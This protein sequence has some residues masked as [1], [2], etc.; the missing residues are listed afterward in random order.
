MT[1]YTPGPR[2]ARTRSQQQ[3]IQEEMSESERKRSTYIEK[4]RKIQKS[5]EDEEIFLNWS[6][7]ELKQRL[8][9]LEEL[10]SNLNEI[11]MD[12]ICKQELSMEQTAE[13]DEID[14]LIMSLKAKATDKIEKIDGENK[15]ANTQSQASTSHSIRV[16]QT[17]A[18]GNLPNTWGTFNGDYAKWQSFRD[19]WLPVHE[20]KDIKSVTK[21]QA[22][23][24][25]C[26][27]EA[28]GAL[29]EWDLTDE[30][31]LKAF[32]RLKAIYEDEY[33]QTQAFMQK[34]LRLPRMRDNSSKTIRKMIDTVQQH[35]VGA[36]RCIKTDE[37]H[38]YA[39]FTVI[40]KMDSNT[41]SAWEKHRRALTEAQQ[42]AAETDE[43]GNQ[44]RLG[45]LI[46]SWKE[47]EQF[48]ESEV[49]IR[50][51][52]ESREGS[53][54][55][56]Q[57]T[58]H[59]QSNQPKQK[60]FK[61]N[62]FNKKPNNQAKNYPSYVICGACDGNHPVHKCDAFKA[63]NLL[64]RKN[65]A[66]E[67]QLCVKC[68]RKSHE[69]DCEIKRC[70]DACPQCPNKFH[71]SLLCPNS[72]KAF[73]ARS[74]SQ[75]G[76]KRP[77]EA[78]GKQKYQGKRPRTDASEN[79]QSS[80]Y[81]IG[82]WTLKAES[83]AIKQTNVKAIEKYDGES[84]YAILLATMNILIQTATNIFLNCR[85][86]SDGG[87]TVSVVEKQFVLKN[88]IRTKR[89]QKP[90]LGLTGPDVLKE[91]IKVYIH[92]WFNKEISI[93]AEL[94]VVNNLDGMYPYRQVEASKHDITHLKLADEQFDIP[95]PVD[96]LLGAEIYTQ[97]IDNVL[98][99]HKDGA[100]MQQTSFG[101]I[102]LGK[103]SVKQNNE[104]PILC[105]S[106]ANE[107]NDE[108]IELAKA[109]NKFWEIE[110]INEIQTDQNSEEQAV[111][112]IFMKTHFREKSGR[113]VVTIP[114]KSGHNLG[115]SR[116]IA[117]K[118]FLQLERKF[119]K[120]PATKAKYVEF[121]RNYQS[122]GYLQAAN[123]VYDTKNAYWLPHHAVTKKFRVV[124][125]ASQKTTTGES[126]NSIQMA[127]P[128]LQLDLALQLMRFRK[129]K[130]AVTTD[131]TK[132]FNKIGLNQKQWDFQRIFWRESP[133]HELK[134]YVITV[135]MFGLK[136]SPF[137]AVKTLMQ[138]ADDHASQFPEAA[139]AIKTCF[140][141]DDGIFGTN[142]IQEAKIL[143]KEV[144]YVLNRSNFTLKSWSSNSKEL[145]MYMNG[146]ANE[147]E[148]VILGDDDETKVLGMI[149]NKAK[150]EESIFVKKFEMQKNVTKRSILKE[151]ATLYDPNGFIAPVIVKA[152]MI[153]QNIWRLKE[154]DWDDAVPENIKS[155][156]LEIYANLPKLSQFTKKRWL[157]TYSESKVEI[158]AFCDASGK[159]YGTAIY[160]RVIDKGKISCILL[161]SKS[162]V[163]PLKSISIP[164]LELLAAVLLSNQIEA[165]IEAMQ[166]KNVSVTLYSD[167]ICV[168]H[169]INKQRD[170]LKAFVANRIETIQKKT[171]QY[172]W[173]H[174]KSADNPADLV[175]RG[176]K[177]EDF[178]T[179][180]Q[181][182]EGP[183]WLM[184]P[185]S[186][187]PMPKMTVSA[188]ARAEIVKEC[189]AKAE[190]VEDS[191][192]K[193]GLDADKV[194]IYLK[195]NNWNKIVN[196]TAYVFR[197]MNNLNKKKENLKGRYL[198]TRERNKAV[199]FWVKYEQRYYFKDEIKC[200]KANDSMPSKSK[201][202]SLRPILDK[203]GA[204]RVGGRID[205]ANM[206]Y[207]KRH[208]YIIPHKSRLS[209]L[210]LKHAHETLLHGGIQAMTYLLRKSFWIPQ[211][212]NEA[213]HFLNTCVHCVKHAQ[214]TT[215]Q[216]IA[217][218][219]SVRTTPALPF[220]NVGVDMAGPYSLKLT[221]KV[222]M[223]T[224]NRIMPEMKGW[225]AVF[226]CLVT[227]AVHLEPTDG[228]STD[229]FLHAYQRFVSRRGNPERMYSDNGTNF[230]GANNELANA[231]RIWQDESI[232]HYAQLGGTEWYFITPSAPHEGG[233]W[234]AAV[235]SMKYHL[236]RVIGTQ[237]YSLK[238]ITTLTASVEA[239]MNSRPLC[240]L[241]D[242]AD[243]RDA[244]SPAHFLIG[245]AM[246]LPLH[247]KVESAEEK[248]L[249]LMFSK[250]QANIQSF[251][252]QWSEDYLQALTQLP[253]WR[254]Q[255][256]NLKIDQLV[257]IK[258]ENVPPTYWAMGRITQVNKGSDGNVRSVTL[259]TQAGTLERSVRKLCIL[260]SDIE[261]KYWNHSVNMQIE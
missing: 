198:F 213:R 159:A 144:E 66:C 98:Y 157:N 119:E 141:M 17:D 126:L 214:E 78:K 13:N 32:A 117:L 164:R 235:K 88:N 253:K 147:N 173:K 57:H 184:Q 80:V 81:K 135:V 131:I 55:Q 183:K 251:W 130:I 193:I 48:L 22:L 178:L 179:S 118:Q 259:K 203:N 8:K 92:P 64:G 160:L 243:D 76:K 120:D 70:N 161:S 134:E 6:K 20:N 152:K 194:P 54:K 136:S 215:K 142:N 5:F 25:A 140:Y 62:R 89:C 236:K 174:V 185:E 153:M 36:N 37:A 85:A 29:G 51:H 261:L 245:R 158:H 150:D 45:K 149:W 181:W 35:I 148:T 129:H 107:S 53:N 192:F 31:Y 186:T 163:A 212:R 49:T 195:F 11:N 155:E 154:T 228:M 94:F 122:L 146:N 210:L 216:I 14:D 86:L 191:I 73:L 219:P 68:L 187:W 222:N 151:T 249:K 40:D 43:D 254:K 238:G 59:T 4:V 200:I 33:M 137:N 226:V 227:R 67:K 231:L 176:M 250:L 106:N 197:Y 248:S 190:E 101:N 110:E 96:A 242:D 26:V 18:A 3:R 111:Q 177:I 171:K 72:E 69:G 188:D 100:I 167:S 116:S 23:K 205:K 182:L 16:I 75:R 52:A 169:W 38:P 7:G 2:K 15:M 79:M 104:F 170:D 229:D 252:K 97:I 84:D 74:N 172:V 60:P 121:M 225:I 44:I 87:A 175:S 99:K 138:C 217:E 9:K 102:I 244:L 233:M 204:V 139:K 42:Q 123:K 41:F 260:P 208:Q 255:Y 189:K 221:D 46:P 47:L 145:E 256:E 65:T 27:G 241:S 143:C 34:L 24:T 209:Y 95:A 206:S 28:A 103:F 56:T 128:K 112:D 108:C 220:V 19:R 240:A 71:N 162:R 1:G 223:T 58:Q 30:N 132:M 114:I 39:V 247:E 246:K 10:D 21:F 133:K 113:Y 258:N 115:E 230:V 239:C 257:I 180:K 90:V 168:L 207:A 125:N 91:K 156:W 237:K 127:S 201:I 77:H 224:R 83:N 202:A 12:L 109:L 165:I 105:I 218:L 211:L 196:T 234:E 232:Q 82:D 124:V 166:F 199:E 93:A 63:M 61:K 50:V